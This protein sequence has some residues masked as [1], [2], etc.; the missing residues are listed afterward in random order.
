MGNA[1]S[2]N[3]IG[4]KGKVIWTLNAVLAFTPTEVLTSNIAEDVLLIVE[5]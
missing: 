3:N 2:L 1:T 5:P 4:K